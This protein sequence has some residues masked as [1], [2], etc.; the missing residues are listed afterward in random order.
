MSTRRANPFLRAVPRRTNR[1]RHREGGLDG[2]I[3]T[4]LTVVRRGIFNK[5]ETTSAISSGAIFQFADVF[6]P[7]PPNSVS[8]LPGMM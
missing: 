6:P 8:T 4:R 5:V 7:G 2:R 1:A 3:S